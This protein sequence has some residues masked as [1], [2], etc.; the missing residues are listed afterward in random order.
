MN[1]PHRMNALGDGMAFALTDAFEAY[2]D[3]KQAR[4][5]ILTGAGDRAFC[6]GADLIETAEIRQA[7]ASG[8]APPTRGM[9]RLGIVNMSET[10]GL[11]KPTIAAINGFAVA[12]NNKELVYRGATMDPTTSMRFGS[13]LEQNLRGMKDSIEGPLA[14]SEKRRPNFLDE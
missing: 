12:G 6:A 4:V 8:K 11:W 2:R 9:G 10:L 1:R 5:A 13:A 7:Q 14:F 3:D